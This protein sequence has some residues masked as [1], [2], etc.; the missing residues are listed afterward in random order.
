MIDDYTRRKLNVKPHVINRLPRARLW[1]AQACLRL[2][3]RQLA[4]AGAFVSGGPRILACDA[5]DRG[6]HSLSDE[7]VLRSAL[8]MR[9]T[10]ADDA[11]IGDW[12]QIALA[13]HQSLGRFNARNLVPVTD[14]HSCL[15][16]SRQKLF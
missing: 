14:F 15:A 16:V 9:E 3:P 10:E 6:L 4:A 2:V 13:K 7:I 8:T 5:D 12:L 11:K 1:S